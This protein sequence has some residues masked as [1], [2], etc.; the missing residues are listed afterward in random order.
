MDCGLW[1]VEDQF[2][3]IRILELLCDV[4]DV[5]SCFENCA[6]LAMKL[7]EKRNTSVS[8]SSEDFTGCLFVYLFIFFI[9]I[10]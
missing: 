6:D 3:N 7:D 2:Q 1:I 10:V 8:L 4:G 9:F 5:A